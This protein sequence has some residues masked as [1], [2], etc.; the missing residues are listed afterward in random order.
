MKQEM[1]ALENNKT[2][3]ISNLPHGKKI[4]GCKWVYTLK[5]NSDGS[6]E[7][8]KARLVAK[9][10]TQTY[11]VDYQENFAPVAKMDTARILFSLATNFNWNLSQ[12]DAKN[13]FL[14]GTLN[15]EIYM[16]IPPGFKGSGNDN[17]VCRIKKALYGLK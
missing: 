17:K 16:K 7:R 8:Y 1:Q 9:R 5:Y 10:Y 4:V 11:G 3:E 12:F 2:W 15:E 14:H 13:T 6:L